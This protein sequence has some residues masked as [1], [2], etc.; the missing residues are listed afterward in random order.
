MAQGGGWR[1]CG[2]KRSRTVVFGAL[3]CALA[4]SSLGC[5]SDDSDNR[6][7][8]LPRDYVLGGQ[9]GSL[10]P[11][12]GIAPLSDEGLGV[13]SGD[14]LAVL[15]TSG[16]SEPDASALVAREGSADD[17]VAVELVPL[18]DRGTYLVRAA[19]SVAAG[20]YQLTYGQGT[21]S[22]VHVEEQTPALPLSVGPL[23]LAPSD[24]SCPEQLRFELELDAAALAYAPLAR[25]MLRVDYGEEQLWVDYGALP[26]E[27]GAEGSHGVLELPRCGTQSC[28]EHGSHSLALSMQVAGEDLAAAP[29]ELDF[30]VDC[31]AL[32]ADS[33]DATSE[34]GC[35]LGGTA[36]RREH[37]AAL[38]GVAGLIWLARRRRS[39][40]R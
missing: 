6:G 33:S 9:T 40:L 39:R 10:I 11:G 26:I 30:V 25:F 1:R 8:G 31:P 19:Q 29:L 27:S 21:S 16:C 13:P 28:L 38:A 17:G 5:G 35:A 32:G 15:Y 7:I 3:F 18:D 23:R 4:L 34:S 2:A 22:S 36:H 37:D 24:E 14:A 12:C 20:D